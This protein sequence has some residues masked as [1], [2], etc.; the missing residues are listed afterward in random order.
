MAKAKVHSPL[1]KGHSPFKRLATLGPGPRR[2]PAIKA[3]DR[4]VCKKG[5]SVTKGGVKFY[6]QKCADAKTGKTRTIKTNSEWKQSYN[7]EYAKK[8]TRSAP[9]NT[10]R[11][12]FKPRSGTKLYE[13]GQ[14]ALS[15]RG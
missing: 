3:K 7:A 1:D 9:T 13:A 6:V 11:R 14:K 4:Y 5:K 2:R 8:R 10:Y 15:R 12:G